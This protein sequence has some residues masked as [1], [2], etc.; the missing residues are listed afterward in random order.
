MTHW[1]NE[2]RERI[3]DYERE[4]AKI[5]NP[6]RRA[7][8][9]GNGGSFTLNELNAL[10]I[11]QGGCCFYCKEVLDKTHIDHKTP[12][13]RGGTSYIENIALSCPTCNMK[14]GTKTVEEF[15]T[16]G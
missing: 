10:F 2:N 3:K 13:S 15:I 6:T 16:D 12:I 8:I 4:Y 7:R 9:A 14:K 5:K 1:R 11:E